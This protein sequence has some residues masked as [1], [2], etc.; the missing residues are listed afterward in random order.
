MPNHLDHERESR[1]T[2]PPAAAVELCQ[3]LIDT[4]VEDERW[5]RRDRFTWTTEE[6][7]AN[8]VTHPRDRNLRI[9]FQK[10]FNASCSR[11]TPRQQTPRWANLAL[12]GGTDSYACVLLE[13]QRPYPVAEIRQAWL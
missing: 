3:E 6:A 13:M 4:F 7:V 1:L 2:A 9:D 11:C 10:P 5:R 12:Q 8:L